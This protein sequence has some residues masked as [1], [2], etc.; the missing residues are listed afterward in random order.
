M[1]HYLLPPPLSM[2][3]SSTAGGQPASIRYTAASTHE[4]IHF[5]NA[6]VSR[7]AF[8]HAKPAPSQATLSQLPWWR[9]VTPS[10]HSQHRSRRRPPTPAGSSLG[11][12]HCAGPEV[13]GAP[14]V[15]LLLLDTRKSRSTSKLTGKNTNSGKKQYQSFPGT[16]VARV[17]T[18]HYRILAVLFLTWATPFVGRATAGAAAVVMTPPDTLSTV[19]PGLESWD[20][21]G[22][23]FIDPSD[24]FTSDVCPLE[25]AFEKECSIRKTVY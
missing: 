19:V 18:L 9:A 1:T 5:R 16:V 24:I 12:E 25:A 22:T 4:S 8:L 14:T 3:C 15:C 11:T 20:E 10:A 6:N 13:S 2:N 21:A 17:Q 7:P 23:D